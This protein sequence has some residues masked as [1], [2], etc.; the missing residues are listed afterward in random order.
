M[1]SNIFNKDFS[2]NILYDFLDQYCIIEN[3]YYI[4]H[5]EIY[6]KYEYFK[7]LDSFYEIMKNLYKSN[8]KFYLERNYSYNNLITIIRHICKNN[9]IIYFSKIIYNKSKY[10]INYYIKKM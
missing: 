6:K 1:T 7:K 8:K 5:K 3:N 10:S 2:N 9:N 4:F